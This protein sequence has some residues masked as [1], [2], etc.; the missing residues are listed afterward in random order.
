[1]CWNTLSP[2]NMCIY[3]SRSVYRRCVSCVRKYEREIA[4]NSSDAQLVS[5]RTAWEASRHIS[6]I[7]RIHRYGSFTGRDVLLKR[8]DSIQIDFP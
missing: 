1:M 8:D 6:P 5:Q 3:L 2:Q 7:A 4:A